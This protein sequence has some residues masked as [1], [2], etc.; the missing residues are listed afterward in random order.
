MRGNLLS[1]AI[2]WALDPDHRAAMN[3][4]ELDYLER[5]AAARHA[6][7][8]SAR[9]RIRL[10]RRLVGALMVLV[11]VSA[12]LTGYAFQAR[13]VA[14]DQRV[15][16][17]RARDEA[18]SRQ[19]A[20]ESVR[21]REVDPALAEQLALAAYRISPTIDARS[22]LFDTATDGV[23]HRLV[24]PSGPTMLRIDPTGRTAAISNALDGTVDLRR[25][26]DGR[27]GERLAVVPAA[28]PAHTVF[29]L[30]FS[31]DGGTLAIGGQ[32]PTVRL[33]D[34]RDPARPQP[35]AVAPGAFTA[36]EA[37]AFSPDGTRL[38]AGGEGPSLRAWAATAGTWRTPTALPVAGAGT[39]VVQA[40][41]F[42]TDGRTLAIGGSSG[43]L[44]FWPASRLDTPPSTLPTDGSPINAV[45]WSPDSR[46]ILRGARDGT[47]AI[48]DAATRRVRAR[49][50]TGFTS[51]V[52]A[53]SY[54]PRG[55]A[56]VVG[57]SNNTIALF[58]TRT[59][60]RLTTIPSAA[61]VTAVAYAPG[62]AALHIAAADGT[63]RTFPARP[64]T[65]NPGHGALFALGLSRTGN[66]LAV[67]ST[68]P[69]GTATLWSLA[70]PA[71]ARMP[72]PARPP[73]FGPSAGSVAISPDGRM[74]ATGNR[75]GT[76]LLMHDNRTTMLTGATKLIE[77]I[78]FSP[79]GQA[80]AASSDDGFVHRWDLT[81]PA[82]P[83]RLPP[84]HSGGLAASI[85]FSPDGRSLAAAS[86]D[87]S[88]H[89]W[90]ITDPR[91]ARPL[92]PLTGFKNYAWSVAFSP[93]SRTLAAGSAD[94][95]IRLWD[96]S[97]P[98]H[99]ASKGPPL[100]GPTNY[101]FGVAFSPDGGHLAATGGDGS[102][103]TWR[104]TEGKEAQPEAALHA[105]NPN[106]KT[107]A[108]A[109]T[110]DGAT[111]TA[112][113]TS[114]TV[115]SWPTDHTKVIEALCAGGGA[116]TSREWSKY[117][118]GTAYRKICP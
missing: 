3:A 60:D 29:A 14:A 97:N 48:V 23:V 95:T 41:A 32:S 43:A 62:G 25:Y 11:V 50:A 74:L 38:V 65:I 9:E 24:G 117:V 101:V 13:N 109:Y 19:V 52:N 92:P 59:N 87:H 111:L 79:D 96:V 55:D 35:L 72:L 69:G 2:E 42:S 12:G 85:A 110:P 46:S 77:S 94:D 36:V 114:G 106:G 49:L 37:L 80:V 10:L 8:R 63:V 40:A 71:P 58:D 102:V 57:G 112:V 1:D 5:S 26:A 93:D 86:V 113:G 100:T 88:V 7:Q 6:E 20:I 118:P 73:R 51:W 99:S 4:V 22:A 44:R 107:Y 84:L 68:G 56:I 108:V 67:A 81:D 17:D 15:A 116:L 54:A 103:W 76:I 83:R 39:E 18:L 105:A 89:R 33:I 91:A 82:R 70:G 45:A 115:T 98:E 27:L 90:D 16:A 21:A 104:L 78:Q 64:R 28:G 34:V 75:A 47:V 61:Q 53:M 30:A 31:P 66:R